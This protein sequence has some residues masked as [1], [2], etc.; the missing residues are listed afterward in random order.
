M[1]RIIQAV[2]GLAAA[3]LIMTVVA[4]SPAQAYHGDHIGRASRGIV[5]TTAV[6]THTHVH[7]TI[8]GTYKYP[9][10][11]RHGHRFMAHG[12][13]V[14]A[15]RCFK[16]ECH[17]RAKEGRLWSPHQLGRRPRTSRGGGPQAGASPNFCLQGGTACAAPWAW[18]DRW[19]GAPVRTVKR[20]ITDPC[21]AGTLG[22]FGV[23]VAEKTAGAIAMAEGT[24]SVG[25]KVAGIF[26]PEGYAAAGLAGCFVGVGIHGVS[27]VKRIASALN[28]FNRTGPRRGELHV[29]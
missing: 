8:I 2:C 17:G 3:A 1:K 27:S 7:T 22:G 5:G 11:G 19:T 20:E 28:P 9:R 21:I 26:A 16:G 23:K 4:I 25:E 12:I 24:L 10:I 29:R 15:Q 6:N 13:V 14:S 18:V